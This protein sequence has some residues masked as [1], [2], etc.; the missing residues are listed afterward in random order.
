MQAILILFLNPGLERG[1]LWYP[2]APHQREF[3]IS[4][5]AVAYLI[6]GSIGWKGNN[7]K[8][9]YINDSDTPYTDTDIYHTDNYIYIYI[10]IP[11]S[12]REKKHSVFTF[13]ARHSATNPSHNKIDIYFICYAQST[14]K[15]HIREKQ[16]VFMS[17]VTKSDSLLYTHSIVEGWRNLGENEVEWAGQA[18][19]GRWKPCQQAQHDKLYSDPLQT[20]KEGTF[21]PFTTDRP[22]GSLEHIVY[23]NCT[24]VTNNAVSLPF[25]TS[26]T[27]TVKYFTLGSENSYR[28]D[29]VC[30]LHRYMHRVSKGSGV[31]RRLW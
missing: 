31:R 5:F 29:P 28:L 2:W 10:C 12:D 21:N 7:R 6:A 4:A 20:W 16:N 18:E 9:L 23:T 14:V 22:K 3:L 17:Q 8:L 15:G 1:N 19:L 27:S 24:A 11:F 25:T 30:L 13:V 26:I